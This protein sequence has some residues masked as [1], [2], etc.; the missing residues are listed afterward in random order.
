MNHELVRVMGEYDAKTCEWNS[1]GV[2]ATSRLEEI[3]GTS[4]EH[5][6][7]LTGHS[8][9]LREMEVGMIA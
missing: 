9:N 7:M 1:P 8:W 2:K 4:Y 3:L 6:P 5:D